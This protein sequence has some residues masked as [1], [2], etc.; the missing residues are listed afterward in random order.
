MK[1][2]LVGLILTA[3]AVVGGVQ[4]AQNLR[5]NPDGTADWVSSDPRSVSPVGAVHLQL[6]I[7]DTIAGATSTTYQLISP[8]S[9]AKIV[10]VRVS[11]RGT[12]GGTAVVTV[13][14]DRGAPP[15][16][17]TAMRITSTHGTSNAV[18]NIGAAANASNYAITQA[19][20][21]PSGR[22]LNNAV[23]RGD[24]IEVNVAGGTTSATAYLI[25]TI[26]PK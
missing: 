19:S 25:L 14:V 6:F 26:Q 23:Q 11:K 22:F 21:L 18:I 12:G 4:A 2:V 17:T 16:L 3:L 1:K 10:D 24:I 8:I 15:S 20:T 9:N 7:A 13:T 5:Q